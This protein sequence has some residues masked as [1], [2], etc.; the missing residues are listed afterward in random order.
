[1]LEI[2]AIGLSA[3]STV[4]TVGALHASAQKSGSSHARRISRISATLGR[5]V[6]LV[7]LLTLVTL[8]IALNL[9]ASAIGARAIDPPPFVWL[10][11]AISLSALLV[12]TVVLI[13]QNRQTRHVEQR[14]RLD[15]QV[16]L[17]AEQKITKIVDLL[18]ELR[19]DMPDVRNRV[20]AVADEMGVPVN[21]DA[22][23]SALEKTLELRASLPPKD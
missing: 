17:L 20:D 14:S 8:W 19:R 21:T 12:S 1:M 5:P 23:I 9:T 18:E 4:E 3:A 16:N 11:G 10:Q 6:F 2:K 15:L 22:V 13:T 7:L